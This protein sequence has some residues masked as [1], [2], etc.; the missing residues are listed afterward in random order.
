MNKLL[1]KLLSK[2]PVKV[3]LIVFVFILGLAFFVS[4]ITLS[5]G[6]ETL[7]EPETTTYQDNFRYQE[8]FGSDPIMIV[9]EGESGTLFTYESLTVINWLVD[10]LST[11][12]GIF[13]I[14]SPIGI[15]N[16]ATMQSYSNYQNG[17]E[18]LSLGL[19]TLSDNMSNMSFG[20]G[21][22]DPTTLLATF[23]TLS[24]A[25]DQ[26][27]DNFTDQVLVF[28]NMKTTVSSEITR[29][30]DIKN[31]LDPVADQTQI[32]SLT[33]TVTILTTINTLYD[34]LITMNIQLASGATTT[35][36]ALNQISSQLSTL[37]SSVSGA[38][39]NITI[40]ASNLQVMG[41]TLGN[42]AANFNMFTG[43]FPTS[44]DTLEMMVYPEGNLNPMFSMYQLDDTHIYM[45]IIPKE[46]ITNDEIERIIDVTKTSLKSTM[47]DDALISG[48]PV[49]DYD[50]QSTM[51]SSM[52]VMMASAGVTM[53]LVLLV[54]FPVKAR[55]LPLLIVMVAV[56]TTVGIMGLFSIPLTMVSMAVFPVLIGLGIDYSIQFHNRYMEETNEV[57]T[58]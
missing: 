42:L 9:F 32:Q 41:N 20:D 4:Q 13:F 58:V 48:K 51:M 37:F 3:V 23:E 50:I 35:S 29:L 31:T 15:I 53:V 49:L 54:L 45:S 12:D 24:N 55:L 57:E 30:E 25:Q 56:I 22:L 28:Q 52:R 19:L 2:W 44:S 14:N 46:S 27:G 1:Y 17:L 38:Q 18:E 39:D 21:S 5:T 6:N 7:I 34:Q 33:Q 8:T 40:V 10:E 26:L 16:N 36:D 11:L 47:H 43:T